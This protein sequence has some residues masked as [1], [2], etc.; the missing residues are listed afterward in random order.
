MPI[1]NKNDPSWERGAQDF[2]Y[3]LMLAMLE[4]SLNPELGMT[5]DKLN[6]Y[7]LA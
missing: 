5:K 4:D 2:L 3:G 1:E 7:N 6:F